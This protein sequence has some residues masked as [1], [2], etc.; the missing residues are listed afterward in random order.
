[1]VVRNQW[2]ESDAPRSLVAGEE[3]A[4][5]ITF[6]LDRV[7]YEIDLTT[8]NAH[9]LRDELSVYL[10]KARKAS[11]QR[12]RKPQRASATAKD[13]THRFREWAQKNGY[14]PSSRGRISRNIIDAYQAANS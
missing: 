14:N 10:E 2:F 3:A 6:G 9:Q 13:E 5:T 1:M 7:T 11:G 12:G 8:D 4:E